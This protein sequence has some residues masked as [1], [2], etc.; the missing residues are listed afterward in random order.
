VQ[1][2][3][4]GCTS[5]YLALQAPVPTNKFD[6]LATLTDND[7]VDVLQDAGQNEGRNDRGPR[8]VCLGVCAS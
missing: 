3:Q 4:E 1:P 6:K 7:L 2:F 5:T 8:L